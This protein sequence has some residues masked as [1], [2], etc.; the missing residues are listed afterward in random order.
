MRTIP[1]S[2][3]A[4]DGAR[5]F[6]QRILREEEVIDPEIGGFGVPQVYARLGKKQKA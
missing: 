1:P 2:A 3:F 4:A 5:G 6:W